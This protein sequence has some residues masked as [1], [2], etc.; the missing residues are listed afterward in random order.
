M[1]RP[2]TTHATRRSRARRGFT[3]AE[4]LIAIGIL[5]VCLSLGATLFPLAIQSH[6]E[7]VGNTI[8]M[9]ICENA[10]NVAKTVM[11]DGQ[12]DTTLRQIDNNMVPGLSPFA[13]CYPQLETPPPSPPE[14]ADEWIRVSGVP[15]AQ[16]RTTKGAVVFARRLDGGRNYYELIA[17]AY[18]KS[19]PTHSVAVESINVTF[20]MDPARPVATDDGSNGWLRTDGVLISKSGATVGQYARIDSAD[21]P[22]NT[23][24]LKYFINASGS[25]QVWLLVEKDASGAVIRH[26]PVM[27]VMSTR[28]ALKKVN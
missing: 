25:T 7:S 9:L 6:K 8:G 21:N 15:D 13:F 23:A 12:A 14:D 4:L 5:G 1:N 22:G 24:K 26:N 11:T 16:P 3:L 17:V 2:Q 19:D 27:A 18:D 10:L 20:N 28:T